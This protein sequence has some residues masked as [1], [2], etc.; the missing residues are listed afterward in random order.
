MNWD[1]HDFR[2][3]T[4]SSLPCE[5]RRSILKTFPPRAQ[6]LAL[7][8]KRTPNWHLLHVNNRGSSISSI[9]SQAIFSRFHHWHDFDI[10]I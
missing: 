5:D 8:E 9:S 2:T 1:I 3:T 7:L 6:Y 4:T 10:H